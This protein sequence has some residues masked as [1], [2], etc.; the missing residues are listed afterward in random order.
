MAAF[1]ATVPAPQPAVP[2]SLGLSWRLLRGASELFAFGSCF[3]LA[4][5]GVPRLL[6]FVESDVVL[7]QCVLLAT[8][9]LYASAAFVVS[10]RYPLPRAQSSPAR[11]SLPAGIA[12]GLLLCFGLALLLPLLGNS[13]REDPLIL[14]LCFSAAHQP[15]VLFDLAVLG[16]LREEILFRG[17]MFGRLC[18]LWSPLPAYAASSGVFGAL[19]ASPDSVKVVECVASGL[20]LALSYRLTLT[21]WAPLAIHVFNNAL[22]SL[23]TIGLSPLCSPS[24]V[25]RSMRW[26]CSIED[27]LGDVV[28]SGR[29]AVGAADDTAGWRWH[30]GKREAREACNDLFTALDRGGKGYLDAEETGFFFSLDESALDMLS[31]AFTVLHEDCSAEANAAAAVAAVQPPSQSAWSS[32]PALSLPSRSFFGSLSGAQDAAISA[33]YMALTAPPLAASDSASSASLVPPPSIILTRLSH[34]LESTSAS[35]PAAASAA[36]QRLHGRMR[37]YYALFVRVWCEQRLGGHEAGRLSRAD[38]LGQCERGLVVNP[39]RTKRMVQ[40]AALIAMGAQKHPLAFAQ[41]TAAAAQPHGRT[42]RR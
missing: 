34:N 31:A 21:L 22:V 5:L 1:R 32:S 41:S 4:V 11:L 8:I 10:R 16:P 25:E 20:V 26:A 36:F 19:H 33:L 42:G 30:A 9:A 40:Q 39:R 27:A 29:T 38:F 2:G 15:V 17:L 6:F 7:S 14:M 28:Y 12:F 35:S 24:T 18:R 23:L 3:V 37:A 13:T